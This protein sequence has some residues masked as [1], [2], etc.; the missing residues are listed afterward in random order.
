MSDIDFSHA[1][2][3]PHATK[4]L[5]TFLRF[6]FALKEAGFG[7]EYG[8]AQVE[9][10]RVTKRLGAA[11]FTRIKESGRADALIRRPPKKQ[12]TRGHSLEWEHKDSPDTISDLFEAVRRVRNNLVHGGKSGDPDYDPDDP[13]RN[14]KLIREAQWVVEQALYELHDVR[15]YFEGRY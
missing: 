8:D 11:F 13:H 4:L 14:E 1:Q 7:P 3:P 2:L 10:G 12:I 5:A 9:W 15:G 6:E